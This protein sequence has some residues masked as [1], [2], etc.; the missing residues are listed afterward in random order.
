VSSLFSS[1]PP[2]TPQDIEE[3]HTALVE[4]Y[5]VEELDRRLGYKWGASA[6]LDRTVGTEGGSEGIFD[7]ALSWAERKGRGRDLLALAW[8]GNCTNPYLRAAAA[9]LLPDLDQA[10]AL[11]E[12]AVPVALPDSLEAMVT[13]RSKLVNYGEFLERYQQLGT[14][15]CLVKT[16][17][18]TGTG[19]LIGSRAVLT[20]Y[21]VVENEL[22]NPDSGRQIVCRFDFRDG[23]EGV[24]KPVDRATW[25]G[26][27]SPYSGSDLGSGGDPTPDQLDFALLYLAEPAE[28]ERGRWKLSDS[29][30]I[31]VPGDVVVV[32]EH[33]SGE[34]L[35]VAYGTIVSLPASG[36]RY[37][38]NCTTTAG[39]SG[40]P[41]LS[42][43]LELLG[44]HHAAEPTNAP[45]YNQAIPA[46]QIARALQAGGVDPATI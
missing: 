42:A 35:S 4:G 32:A 10:Y 17:T 38:Y 19:F 9:R 12:R 46:F 24:D 33:P 26:P 31:I 5:G 3:I 15:I 25:H 16:P 43:D 6:R 14:A 13:A 34:Q 23:G 36:L 2:L 28:A 45:T 18:K 20:N 40:S 29:A 39:A 37:R 30:P 11:Y 8:S 7:R 22:A 44:L 21:H 41:V 1:L 27:S